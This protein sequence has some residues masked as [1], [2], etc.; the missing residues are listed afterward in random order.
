MKLLILSLL[1][2][3]NS[4]SAETETNT[5]RS[6][7]GPSTMGQPTYPNSG[8]LRHRSNDLTGQD[9]SN[10]TMS[11]DKNPEVPDR[12]PTVGREIKGREIPNGPLSG[13]ARVHPEQGP[14]GKQ[15]QEA[16]KEGK[17]EELTDEEMKRKQHGD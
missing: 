2:S 17:L 9:M 5:G 3:V 16:A 4:Y 1:F 13:K 12:N 7:L 6:I 14:E 11:S 8:P 10:S 15:A